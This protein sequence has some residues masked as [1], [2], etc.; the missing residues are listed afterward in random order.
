MEEKQE[1]Q[2]KNEVRE[3]SNEL[4]YRRYLM[5]KGTIREIFHKMTIQEYLALHMIAE[6]SRNLVIYSGRTYLKDLAERMQLTVRQVSKMVRELKDRGMVFWSHDGDGKDG[7]YVTIT[8]TGQ[9]LL[10]EQEAV[11][12]DYY[13][14]VIHKFGKENLIELL[15]LMQQLE[16]IMSCEIEEMEAMDE[17]D[18]VDGSLCEGK[19]RNLP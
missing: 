9:K 17:D 18:K 7:T 3:L 4:L 11:L 12:K 8:E 19:R 1:Q 15:Q 13:G 5:N 6:E 10:E 16:T 2:E 14:K